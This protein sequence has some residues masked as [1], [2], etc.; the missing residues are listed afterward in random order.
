[1][2]KPKPIK[3][4]PIYGGFTGRKIGKKYIYDEQEVM[5]Y[6][7][8]SKERLIKRY[9]KITEELENLA[10]KE[11]VEKFGSQRRAKI[12]R[13]CDYLGME[14]QRIREELFIKYNIEI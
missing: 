3:I 1:M 4:V 10:W 7:E 11:H 5:A 2:K 12:S 9:N 8:Y 6:K 13:K 14:R